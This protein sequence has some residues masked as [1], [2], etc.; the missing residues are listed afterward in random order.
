MPKAPRKRRV[1][2]KDLPA[3]E[4]KLTKKEMQQVRGA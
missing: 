4:R 1:V 3:P 2:I